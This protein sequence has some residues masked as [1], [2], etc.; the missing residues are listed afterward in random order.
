[1][2]GYLSDHFWISRVNALA[3]LLGW[4]A[5]PALRAWPVSSILRAC[6]IFLSIHHQLPNSSHVLQVDSRENTEFLYTAMAVSVDVREGTT[7]GISASDRAATVRAMADPQARAEQFRRPG[8]IVPLRYHPVSAYMHTYMLLASAAG[9][10]WLLRYPP[11]AH[12]C[13]DGVDK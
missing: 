10:G 4:S 12:H 6:I 9:A 3:R 2:S 8:H 5:M 7:T 13:N 11:C 1:M